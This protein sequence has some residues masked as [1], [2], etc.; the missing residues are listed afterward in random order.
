MFVRL[1]FLLLTFPVYATVFQPQPVE[2]QIKESD[3]I[4]IGHYLKSKAIKLDDGSIATQMIFKMNKE[5]GL[6]SDLFGM[7][8]V[9]VHYP[10]GKMDGMEVHVD[11]VPK[12]VPGE[13]V[14][15]MIKSNQDRYWGM[16]L[17]FGTFKVVNYGNETMIVNTIFPTDRK[18]GQMKL[19]EFERN[20]KAIKGSSLKIVMAPVYPTETD[21]SGEMRAPASVVEGQNRSI[22]SKTEEVENIEDQ[23]HISVFWLVAFL[24]IL[25]GIFRLTRQKEAK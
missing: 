20:V 22:A 2:Q 6:Q 17:G 14:V 7:D 10:G 21:E 12:F 3:G 13:H 15:L 19:V 23:P 9:I 4:M 11:G 1:F 18:V 16:N 8:E 24:A 25:G 5:Y